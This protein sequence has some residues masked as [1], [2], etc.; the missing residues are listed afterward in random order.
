MC[1]EERL[2]SEDNF[3]YIKQGLRDN[4]IGIYELGYKTSCDFCDLGM[5]PKEDAILRIADQYNFDKD[6]VAV[7]I[8]ENFSQCALYKQE[9][10]LGPGESDLHLRQPL[11]IPIVFYPCPVPEGAKLQFVS[12]LRRKPTEA[13]F[14]EVSDYFSDYF[15]K[16]E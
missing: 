7:F 1:D 2:Y 3:H 16:G 12:R 10:V 5:M 14:I 6:K 15:K 4:V 8:A 9:R 13:S 11:S